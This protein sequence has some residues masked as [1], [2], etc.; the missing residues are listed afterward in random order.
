MQI[1]SSL[2]AA[3][4]PRSRPSI[5]PDARLRAGR[6]AGLGITAGWLTSL[7]AA[8]A[9]G[10]S[11]DARSWS[12][13]VIG[14]IC[15]RLVARRP[16]A[17]LSERSLELTVPLAGLHAMAAALTLDPSALATAPFFLAAAA[18]A[19]LL[20][21]GR[22]AVLG[23]AAALAGAAVLVAGLGPDRDAG[24]LGHA[25]A[26]A[27]AI[28]LVASIAALVRALRL[29]ADP[30][31]DPRLAHAPLA[32]SARVNPDRLAELTMG[33]DLQSGRGMTIAEGNNLLR[34]VAAVLVDG[35]ARRRAE[36]DGSAAAA[37]L[38][39]QIDRVLAGLELEEISALNAAIGFAATHDGQVQL[40]ADLMHRADEALR[41][42]RA[43][44]LDAEQAQAAA[45]ESAA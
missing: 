3:L 25:V 29:A 8:I 39:E 12:I 45:P 16:W 15:G 36:A 38:A 23:N 27:P 18:M 2:K 21:R 6:L 10:T 9:G 4:A 20:I 37:L 34:D 24:A 28:M 40:P 13:V 7:G 35:A 30:I 11:L 14:L 43:Q 17:D 44:Q 31:G 41:Q 22:I 1:S 19:G 26:L 32:E 33:L 42:A 5:D